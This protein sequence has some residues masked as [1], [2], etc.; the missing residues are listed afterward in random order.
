M[1]NKN[2]RKPNQ[3]LEMRR[4]MRK[5]A[6]L[7]VTAGLTQAEVGKEFGLTQ[8]AISLWET[9]ECRPSLDKIPVLAHLYNVTEQDIFEACMSLSHTSIITESEVNLNEQLSREP[10]QNVQTICENDAGT[11]G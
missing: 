1:Y 2:I 5:L 8:G 11:G 7:R 3:K 9:G 10:V 6:G 4:H